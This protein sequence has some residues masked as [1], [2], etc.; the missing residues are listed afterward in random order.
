M[1]VSQTWRGGRTVLKT[2]TCGELTAREVGQQVTLAG[3]VH[4]RRDHG[5]LVF[6]DLRDR[7]GLTQVVFNPAIAADAHLTARDLR[8]EYCI[9]VGGTVNP[10]PAGT[11]NARLP[12]GEI[13]V[14]ASTLNILNPSKT[15][16][17]YIN[18]PSDVDET[19]RLRYRYLDLRRPEMQANLILRHR[20]VKYIRDFLDAQGFLEIETPILFKSTPEGAREYLVPSRVHAGKFYALPQ[21]PQQFKQLLMVAG[22]EKYFQIARCFRDEDQRADRQIE[23]TQLDLEM[24]WVDED[25]ILGLMEALFS[26]LVPALTRFRVPGPWP[27]LTFD[28]CMRRYGSD[29]PDLRF[30]ME[31]QDISGL[32]A[33]SEFGVFRTALQE[34]GSVRAIAV[35]GAGNYSRRQLDDLTELSKTY[36]ARGLITLSL[37]EAGQAD[38]LDGLTMEQVRSNIARFLTIQQVRSIAQRAGAG[39]GDLV[40]AVA[41]P[42]KASLAALGQ[43]RSELGRR[44]N[45]GDPE[46]MAFAFVTDF[47]LLEWDAEEG[48]WAAT[49]HL[50][51]H[52]KDEDLALLDSDPGRARA[53]QYDII[54]N[55]YEVGGGS[56]R[57]HNQALQSKIFRLLG[58]SDEAA[59]ARFGHMLEAFEYGA[60]PHGG[61]AAGID[62]I[63][64]LLA[65]EPNLREV[66]AFPKNQ[67]ASDVMTDSPS[68][69]TERQLQ[70]L[71]IELVA[72]ARKV[73][74]AE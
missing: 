70:D 27:R 8:P 29:K 66:I 21:S 5:G 9:Q 55:G 15:P 33:D 18:E 20:V 51:T 68:P 60:P 65:S 45:L 14:Q 12:T 24:S 42:T 11:E 57:I 44:L 58:L 43:L 22:Y 74:R 6:I 16:P 10:R 34:G 2:K 61:I 32:V 4:R 73:V 71:H 1:P 36:G 67:A 31:I 13:E 54:C 3:W 69:V 26:G 30:G 25:D 52:P 47:P 46:V 64:M 48:R 41:G 37:G 63:V 53:K 39:V 59:W 62:R 17:F 50:F 56:I 28:D 38:S 49:H 35:P 19:L 23:F 72:D 7:A 40:L